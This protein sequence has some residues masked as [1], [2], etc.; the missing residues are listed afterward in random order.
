MNPSLA[1]RRKRRGRD[2][3]ERYVKMAKAK[4][5]KIPARG[6]WE[7][8]EVETESD[9]NIPLE[10]MKAIVGGWVERWEL[11]G[12]ALD[13][14][15]LFL[16]E[17]GKLNGLSYNPKATVLAEILFHNDVIVGDTFVCAH[18][19]EG[20]SVGLSD[21]QELALRRRLQELGV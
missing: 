9:G 16:N 4:V 8:A 14:L 21:A 12:H 19:G 18:D 3:K 20:R 11:H 17:E 13:G 1:P 10:A 6:D 7:F 15:D 5:L 2:A